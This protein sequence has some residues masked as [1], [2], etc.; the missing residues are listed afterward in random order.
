M[1]QQGFDFPYQTAPDGAPVSLVIESTTSISCSLTWS[2]P[3][4]DQLNGLLRHYVIII[5][6]VDTGRNTSLTSTEPQIALSNLHPF[7][8]YNI[9]VC[10]VTTDIG[11]CVYFDPVQLPQDG[12]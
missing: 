12:K 6:E 11:P 9:A 1:Y 5:E 3:P 2:P 4:E 10:A 8:T 7:Y